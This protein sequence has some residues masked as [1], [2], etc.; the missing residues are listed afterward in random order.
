[1]GQNFEDVSPRGVYHYAGRAYIVVGFFGAAVR[2]YVVDDQTSGMVTPIPVA[3]PDNSILMTNNDPG[4][5]N[6]AAFSF[7][8][9]LRMKSGR[10]ASNA[11]EMMNFS[12]LNLVGEYP[13]QSDIPVN[14]GGFAWVGHMAAMIGQPATTAEFRYWFFDANGAEVA[15]E[16]LPFNGTPP[17]GYTRDSISEV[18]IAKADLDVDTEG[19]RIHLSWEERYRDANM[20]SHTRVYYDQLNCTPMP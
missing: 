2:M 5:V 8:P 19:G 3:M 13:T 12:T 18:A 14:D 6:I 20:Q 9:P 15:F 1:M 10:F 7:G 17:A 16:T 4:G 11:L